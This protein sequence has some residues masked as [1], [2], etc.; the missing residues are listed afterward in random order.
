MNLKQLQTQFS[1]ALFYKNDNILQQ[2]KA[3]RYATAEQR[4]QVYRNSF[5]MG[6]TQS[7]AI[8]Y[9]HTLALV[10]KDFFNSA[11]RQFLLDSPPIENN[12]MTYGHGFDEFLAGLP[13]L[14]SMPYISE[15]ARFEWILEKT[16]N[17]Q[18]EI[19]SL[20]LQPLAR[21]PEHK[22]EKLQFTMASHVT[23]F[24]S[25]QNISHLY[26]MLIKQQVTETDLNFPC[27]CVLKKQPNF[28]VELINLSN[29]EFS[30]LEHLG[31]GKSLGEIQPEK[32]HTQLASLLN[33]ALLNG[34][35]Y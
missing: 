12:M 3:D 17:S 13:Q 31:S 2:I 30:L 7:L 26:Q 35:N 32:L 29:D 22:L 11:S 18:C 28:N 8:T 33:K 4:L 34:F 14:N 21:I 20:D 10:G 27:Y 15:M 1:D 23:L 24:M 25:H 6:I 19:S 9:Q 5:I 16:I